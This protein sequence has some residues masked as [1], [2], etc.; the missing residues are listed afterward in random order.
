MAAPTLDQCKANIEEALGR[1]MTRP[2]RGAVARRVG[3]LLNELKKTD[4]SPG[5]IGRVLQKMMDE[6]AAK[7]AFTERA[8]AINY[9]AYSGMQDFFKTA[10]TAGFK[11]QGQIFQAYTRG[12]LANFPGSENSLTNL[13][14]REQGKR[15]GDFHADLMEAGLFDIAYSGKLDAKITEAQW[16]IRRGIKPDVAKYGAQ[17]TKIAEIYEKHSEMLRQDINAEGGWI[18]KNDDRTFARTHDPN[19]IVSGGNE[20]PHAW[21]SPEAL[22][23]WSKDLQQTFHMDWDKAFNGDLSDAAGATQAERDQRIASLFNQFK[24]DNH[25]KFDSN[26]FGPSKRFG[27]SAHRDIVFK[28][29]ADDLAYFQKYGRGGSLAEANYN[30]IVSSAKQLAMLKRLGVNAEQNVHKFYNDTAKAL[31]DQG[32]NTA[33]LK[34]AYDDWSKNTW[35]MLTESAGHPNDN[36]FGRIASSIRQ[37]TNSAATGMTIFALPSDFALKAG[38]L[39]EADRGNYFGNLL[40]AV[41]TQF[42]P[43][44]LSAAERQRMFAQSG[45]RLEVASRPLSDTMLD[46]TAFGAITKFNNL[47]NRAKL[48]GPWDNSSRAGSIMADGMH[49]QDLKSKDMMDMSPGERRTLERFGI[50]QQEWDII[51]KIPA[52]KLHDGSPAL[53]SDDI[54]NHDL[55]AFSSL[56]KGE[57]PSDITLRRLRSKVGDSFRN[58]TGE[59]ANRTVSAP[60]LSRN[61]RLKMGSNIYDPNTIHGWAAMQALQLKGWVINYT[62]EHL[63]R[64]IMSQYTDYRPMHLAIADMMMGK[65][66]HGAQAVGQYVAGGVAIAY[67]TNALKQLAEG[68]SPVNPMGHVS[69]AATTDQ[70]W[71]NAGMDAF[72]RGSLGIYSDFLLS[73]GKPDE[74]LADKVGRMVLGPEGEF[75]SNIATQLK[76]V[77]GQAI[78]KGGYTKKKIDGDLQKAFGLAYHTFPPDNVFWWKWALDHNILNPMSEAM[79]PGYQKRLQDYAKKDNQHYLAGKP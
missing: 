79:N 66:M 9:N 64:S 14:D 20:H 52:S 50:G 32:K 58:L 40:N 13:I 55:K 49:Y 29:P 21:G 34:A 30:N 57:N 10:E 63:G 54:Y 12:S 76:T 48:H 36:T 4:K 41:V 77:T 75:Y 37:T 67:T 31:N 47:V 46:H 60:S 62:A 2:E 53:Q 44:G 22:A 19:R 45:I 71:F 25:L 26:Y 5:A 43:K 18:P 74:S 39:W 8:V 3:D 59:N 27:L 6:K 68:K 65:N 72:A 69:G 7:K 23:A 70:P 35:R 15:V 38:R 73:R 11:D 17:A 51:R 24:N 42:T 78:Q 1:E 61:A 56:A 33:S 28:S 16:D